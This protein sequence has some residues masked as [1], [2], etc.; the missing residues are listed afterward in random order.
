M[1][2]GPATLRLFIGC[3][4]DTSAQGR[5]AHLVGRSEWTAHWRMVEAASWHVTA[6]FVGAWPEDRVPE[7]LRLIQREA[8]MRAPIQ[9]E[10]GILCSVPEARPRMRWIRFDPHPELTGL[11]HDLAVHLNLSPSPFDPFLPH[12]TLAR[13]RAG[14]RS[15][16]GDEGALW[17]PSLMLRGL[18]LYR[19]D[20]GP[21]GN[22]HRPL[23]TWPFTGTD[24]AAPGAAV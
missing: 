20:P 23:A 24:P 22:V 7:L 8:A 4:L 15:A 21:S 1:P 5:L 9:L 14:S 13:S 10:Q 6:L 19:S 16:V 12:V 11:H 2:H 17:L 3:A 18:S